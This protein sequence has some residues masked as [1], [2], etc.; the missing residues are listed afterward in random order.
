M[1]R[2]IV[3]RILQAFVTIIG[4]SIITFLLTQLS[5]DPVQLMAPQDATQEDVEELR[6][7]LGLDRPIH[8]QYWSYITDAIRG[9]FGESLRWD[10]PAIDMFKDWF[11]NTIRLAVTGFS[12]AVLMGLSVGILSAVKVGTRF[13]NFGKTF[14]LLGQALP[15]FWVGIMLIML[16]SVKLELLP[17]S[18]MGTWKHYI[19][20][21]FTLG[22]LSMAALTRLSRSAMLDVL[23]SEYIKLARIK[24]VR[25]FFVIT[26]HAFKNAGA[27]VLTMAATQFVGALN[28]T[29]I[30]EQIFNWPGLGRL[31]VEAV[32]ARDYPVVQMVILI[33]STI[34]VM[35]ILVVDIL[36]A[37]LDPRIRYTT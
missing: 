34:F 2:Y 24:G 7:I 23:D 30:I 12:F 6:V 26:K 3:I 31:T 4:V 15:G 11:P 16:F 19:M 9:E 5:G 32:F 35:S 8:V 10:M 20:P 21:A 33:S 28:G 17:T 29:M 27:P 14:A 22:W 1:K 13:D 25:E 18:G 37:Y 36:Y